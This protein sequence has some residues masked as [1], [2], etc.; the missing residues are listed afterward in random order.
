MLELLKSRGVLICLHAPV[1]TILERTSRNQNR[2]L[3][4]VDDREARVRE[5]FAQREPVYRRAGTT[6]LTDVRPLREIGEHVLRV[7]RRE[8]RD[9]ARAAGRRPGAVGG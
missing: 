3:I 4:N 7:Y 1:E 5:L 6:V 8:A 2:P 9:F